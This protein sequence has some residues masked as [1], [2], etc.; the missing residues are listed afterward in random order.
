MNKNYW[1]SIPLDGTIADE[2]LF[3]LV[4]SSWHLTK[5]GK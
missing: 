1:V 4:N 3:A 5:K 2:D